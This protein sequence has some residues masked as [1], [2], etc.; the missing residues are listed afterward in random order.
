MFKYFRFLLISIFFG[1]IPMLIFQTLNSHSILEQFTYY[2]NYTK[3]NNSF[4]D[5]INYKIYYIDKSN[6]IH[7]NEKSTN[8]QLNWKITEQNDF[9]IQCVEE[10]CGDINLSEHKVINFD[11]DRLL[12]T[13]WVG[14]VYAYIL[15][16]YGFFSIKRGFNYINLSFIIYGTFGFVLFIMEIIQLFELIGCLSSEFKQSEI[17]V[18]LI[19]YSTF[20]ISFIYGFMCHFSKYLKYATFGFIEGVMT[21]K[22]IF[23]IFLNRKIIKNSGLLYYFLFELFFLGIFITILSYLNN[24]YPK[25]SIANISIISAFGIIFGINIIYGGLPFIPYLILIQKY[26]ETDLY[27]AIL[28]KNIILYYAPLFIILAICGYFWNKNSYYILLNNKKSHLT[29]K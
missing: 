27:E 24:K 25:F 7:K 23:Y 8:F 18:K 14:G 11:F 4:I 3:I 13:N 20:I 19:F 16:L 5:F 6:I 29:K 9:S 10:N 26:Q 2:D 21:T 28:E 17:L 22:I 12:S 1:N 15:I